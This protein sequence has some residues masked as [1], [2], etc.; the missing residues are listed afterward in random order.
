MLILFHPGMWCC[1]YM[2][3]SQIWTQTTDYFQVVG[4]ILGQLSVGLLSDWLGRRWG[5][6]QVGS[7]HSSIILRSCMTT[8]GPTPFWGC[9]LISLVPILVGQLFA[10]L[11]LA[12]APVQ[13]L[14]RCKRT[15]A[16]LASLA[17]KPCHTPHAQAA[18]GFRCCRT[19]GSCFK[20]IYIDRFCI[21]KSVYIL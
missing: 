8:T 14:L 18:D 17:G 13:T 2:E 12:N 10:G 19:Q 3:C 4:I 9:V 21:W 15:A 7:L 1:R 6:I 5:I 20:N 16:S 11:L